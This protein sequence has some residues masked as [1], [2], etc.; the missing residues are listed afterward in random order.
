[1]RKHLLEARSQVIDQLQRHV[2]TGLGV[3]K[4]FYCQVRGEPRLGGEVQGKADVPTMFALLSDVL[5]RAHA[6]IALG[7]EMT[8]CNLEH[9]VKH[10]SIGCVDGVINLEHRV[11]SL[12]VSDCGWL[13]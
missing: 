13:F 2:R 10:H 12:F 7:L 5:L 4:G 6:S 8:S 9:N 3:S 11:D 1:M